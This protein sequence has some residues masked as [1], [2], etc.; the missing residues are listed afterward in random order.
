MTFPDVNFSFTIVAGEK[1]LL[2]MF[3]Y[4]LIEKNTVKLSILLFVLVCTLHTTLYCTMYK[5][6]TFDNISSLESRHEVT[7]PGKCLLVIFLLAD[8]VL[9]FLEA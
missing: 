5:S 8:E 1:M 9:T 2:K 3:L 4:L 7:F 6:P